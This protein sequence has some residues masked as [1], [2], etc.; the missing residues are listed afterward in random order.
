MHGWPFLRSTCYK[1]LSDALR[2]RIFRILVLIC[3]RM[4]VGLLHNPVSNSPSVTSDFHA[5]FWPPP[6]SPRNLAVAQV[7]L[8]AG[9]ARLRTG[10]FQSLGVD[11]VPCLCRQWLYIF[12]DNL[13]SGTMHGFYSEHST[14]LFSSRKSLHGY[15]KGVPSPHS[16]FHSWL[17]GEECLLTLLDLLTFLAIYVI[18][19]CILLCLSSLLFPPPP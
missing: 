6:P 7:P 13:L 9:H 19:T 11:R 10:V 2:L 17:P 5:P 16:T 4:T 12:K 1:Y 3:V 18:L 14:P 15:L 8:E